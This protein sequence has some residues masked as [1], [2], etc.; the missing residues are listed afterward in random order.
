MVMPRTFVFSNLI[1]IDDGHVKNARPMAFDSVDDTPDTSGAG[2]RYGSC[3]MWERSTVN[4]WRVSFT[5]RQGGSRYTRILLDRDVIPS[6]SWLGRTGNR[7]DVHTASG[8]HNMEARKPKIYK[9][10]IGQMI[11]PQPW[12]GWTGNRID[13]HI[14]IV[15]MRKYLGNL[16]CTILSFTLVAW[17]TLL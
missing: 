12:L 11:P 3:G 7:L 10:V 2:K 17:H 13:V 14:I 15:F 6:Q 8:S 4:G 9:D 1:G 16:C 5:G